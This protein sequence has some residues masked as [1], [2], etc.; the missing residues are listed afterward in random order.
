VHDDDIT[1]SWLCTEKRIATGS[2]LLSGVAC[3][4]LAGVR[5][6]DDLPPFSLL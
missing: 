3:C 4:H 5:S 6:G 1:S 2:D